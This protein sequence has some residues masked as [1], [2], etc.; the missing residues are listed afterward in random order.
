MSKQNGEFDT[1]ILFRAIRDNWIVVIV[2]ALLSLA[3]G[4]AYTKLVTKTYTSTIKLIPTTNEFVSSSSSL[5][6]QLGGLADLSSLRTTAGEVDQTTQ[7]I[8]MLQSRRFLMQ[9]IEDNNLVVPILAAVGWDSDGKKWILDSKV[10]DEISNT[11]GGQYKSVGQNGRDVRA[12]IKFMDENLFVQKDHSSGMVV[13]SV[14]TFSDEV[15]SR[16]ANLLVDAFNNYTRKKAVSD[17]RKNIAMLNRELK[18]TS[19]SEIRD[20]I[21]SLLEKQLRTVT[22]ASSNSEFAFD[23]IDYAAPELVA[24]RPNKMYVQGIALFFGVSLGV[25]TAIAM[26]IRKLRTGD[27]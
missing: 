14:T 19:L 16:W 4:G 2:I 24:V 1:F 8:E 5:I 21:F 18:K 15:S 13:I 26:Y 22:L 10:Y 25:I 23:I 12:Y 20:I 27:V 6:N 17:A 7:K 11:W 3:L 9:F